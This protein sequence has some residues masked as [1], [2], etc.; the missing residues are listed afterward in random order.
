MRGEWR[1]ITT[2]DGLCT[3]WPV[4]IGVWYIGTGTTTVCYSTE[5]VDETT[6]PT[7]TVPLG[8]HVTAADKF[9]PGGGEMYATDD[10]VC[11]YDGVDWMCQTPAEGYPYADIQRISH[12]EVEPVLMLTD[13]V[14]YQEQLYDI[15]ETVGIEDARPTWIAVSG[16]YGPFLSPSEI[17]VGTNGYGIVVIQPETREITHHTTDNGLPGNIIRDIEVDATLRAYPERRVWVATDNG[18]GRWDGQHWTAYTTADGLP[19]NDVRGVAPYQGTVWVATAGGAAYF[20][21]RS[22]QAFT[23]ENGLPEVDMSGVMGGGGEVW[24]STR[25]SGL[26]IFVIQTPTQ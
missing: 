12:I 2:A 3:D 17:W 7:R 19:S 26:L 21:G 5:P 6:W 25:G 4:F 13:A 22:W 14:V 8:T 24:F 18:V 16:Q 9:P 10:G 20:D 15:P 23:R 1:R 11:G